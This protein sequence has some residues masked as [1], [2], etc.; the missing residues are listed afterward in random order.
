V[1]R[2]LAPSMSLR[3]FDHGYWYAV[4]LKRFA[5]R[6]GLPAASKLR[7]DELEVAIRR[8]LRSGVLTGR[9]T[10]KAPAVTSSTPRD[11]DLGLRLD[12]RVIRY[13]ND[14]VTK[15]FL[16][17]EAAKRVPGFRRR[18]GARYRLNRW[19]DEQLRTGAAITYRDLVEAYV[20]INRPEER[21]RRIP[22]TRYVYFMSDFLA[23]ERGATTADA[24]AAWHVLKTMDCPKTYRAWRSRRR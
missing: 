14:P 23:G 21:F 16:E 19:P 13:T 15:E 3:N 24:I 17:R 22:H 9:S 7:K 18:S 2:T 5:D 1:K 6:I 4:D 10:G 12:R 20:R 11:V 8:F